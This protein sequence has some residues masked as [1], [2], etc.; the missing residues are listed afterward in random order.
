MGQCPAG[1]RSALWSLFRL[2]AL[3]R[4]VNAR[5][6]GSSKNRGVGPKEGEF[7]KYGSGS[8]PLICP[9]LPLAYGGFGR[10]GLGARPLR[11][12]AEGRE[13]AGFRVVTRS[14]RSRPQLAHAP[15]CSLQRGGSAVGWVREIASCWAG[16][17]W[18]EAR[19]AGEGPLSTPFPGL[20]NPSVPGCS[21]FPP[22]LASPGLPGGF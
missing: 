22:A 3:A 1:G 8:P 13:A 14:R 7:K 17:C 15:V 19:A 10:L 6:T 4:R 12:C 18:S 11:R 2:E 5:R 9:P 20:S 21:R 16:D